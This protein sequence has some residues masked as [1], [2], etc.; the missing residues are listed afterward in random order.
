M[1]RLLVLFA[2][3]LP[4]FASA[5]ATCPAITQFGGVGDGTTDNTAAL[6]AAIGSQSGGR[7]CVSIPAGK[8]AFSSVQSY[9]F[10]Q[11]IASITVQ[12]AGQD[13]TELYFPGSTGGLRFNYISAFNSAHVRNLTI[14][15]STA[16]GGKSAIHLNQT[17]AQNPD[18]GNTALSDVSRVTI[19]GADGYL[20]G[21]Y[22]DNGVLIYG[23]SNVNFDNNYIIG[24]AGTGVN[25]S[26][27][28]QNIPVVFNFANSF[29]NNLGVGILYGA[30]VQ[31]VT[32]SQCNFTGAVIGVK[33]PSGLNTLTQLAVSN[34][35]FNAFSSAISTG[36]GVQGLMLVGNHFLVQPNTVSVSIEKAQSTTVVGNTFEPQGPTLSN[37]YGLVFQSYDFGASVVT[38]NSFYRLTNAIVLA[39]NA[40][41]VNVQS[42]AY[43]GNTNNVV[44]QCGASNGCVV[45]GGSP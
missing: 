35:Q 39:A 34:S 26:G 3:C 17:Q 10:T 23:V 8:W 6:S 31:G 2:F 18:P 32:V 43:F 42:N 40:K 14:T 29:F 22:W 20:V 30:N 11:T 25:L 1:R 4:A 13:V 5:Q 37:Q 15:S 45:G 38:G 33:V 41:N 16:G 9:T 36:S 7:I 24:P 19:R 27:S 44:N 21:N 12:G 28:N